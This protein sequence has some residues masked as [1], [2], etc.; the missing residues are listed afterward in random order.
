[1][2]VAALRKEEAEAAADADIEQYNATEAKERPNLLTRIAANTQA[3]PY[4]RDEIRALSPSLS[5]AIEKQTETR[6]AG[7]DHDAESLKTLRARARS[8]A[9]VL[10]HPEDT[11]SELLEIDDLDMRGREYNYQPGAVELEELRTRVGG[12]A[13]PEDSKS[14]LLGAEA[15]E[16]RAE[17]ERARQ[18]KAALDDALAERLKK[19]KEQEQRAAMSGLI[20][21]DNPTGGELDEF[22]LP[23]Q[24]ATKYVEIKG[25]YYSQE[26]PGKVVFE[27]RGAQLRTSTV[28]RTTISDMVALA[29]AK[30]WNSLK[31]SGSREFRREVW[32]EA[33]SQGIKT[34]GYTPKPAD[35]AALEFIRR[36]RATNS[37]QPA[38]Q[39]RAPRHD[40][41]KNQAQM[42]IVATEQVPA[43]VIAMKQN[44]ALAK[45]PDDTL[46]ALAYWRGIAKEACKFDATES[47]KETLARFDKA[48]ESPAFLDKLES[49]PIDPA[50]GTE[51]EQ[52]RKQTELSL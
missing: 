11:R 38:E 33:E 43:N 41:N 26:Q 36:E 23:R 28:D 39:Q 6:L 42:H 25:K 14:E 45:L 48:A 35:L 31:V 15:K 30:Q 19:A 29:H 13:T 51:N 5:E 22:V 52:N 18:Q 10:E 16:Q 8:E 17:A 40:L 47:Q 24:I 2:T 34:S 49:K 44:P 50:R 12:Q 32:L 3:N 1:M 27:D 4:Y 20:D 37:I 7:G 9:D 21:I 46:T